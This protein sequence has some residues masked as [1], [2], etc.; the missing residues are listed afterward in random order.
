M[1]SDKVEALLSR[2][3]QLPDNEASTAAAADTA[4]PE[5]SKPA[6]VLAGLHPAGADAASDASKAVNPPT[7]GEANGSCA[8]H[9]APAGSQE[10]QRRQRLLALTG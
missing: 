10:F 5:P 4:D 3:L 8:T 9:A 1:C 7:G 6:A 2:P